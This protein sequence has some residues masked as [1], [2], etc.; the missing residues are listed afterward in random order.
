[1]TYLFFQCFA[2]IL[3]AQ[4]ILP[5]KDRIDVAKHYKE[6]KAAFS[7]FEKVHGHFIRTRNVLMH[8]LTWGSPSGTP[9]IWAHGSLTNGYEL[10]PIANHLVK[11]GYYVIAIDYYGH[12]QTPIPKHEVSLYHV[13]DDI[14]FLMDMLRIKKA[15]IGGWSRGG[16]IVTAFYDSYPERVLGLILED[17]GSVNTNTYYHKMDS[18][19]LLNRINQTYSQ[20]LYDTLYASEFDAYHAIY[21]T[22][23]KGNQFENLAWIVQNKEGKWGIGLGLLE[24]FNMQNGAQFLNNI[25]RPSGVPLFAASMSVLEPKI[26]Y[27]N[28]N[29]PC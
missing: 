18:A 19:S 9:L 6:A 3:H 10:L 2:F 15:V 24:L 28:L 7:Q 14:A 29:V 26:V 5:V 16:F 4:N 27:R 21:D 1:V 23:R 12:G 13:A 11:A 22:S 25:L 20:K 8:Y 17:G